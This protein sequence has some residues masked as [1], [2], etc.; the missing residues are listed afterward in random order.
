MRCFVALR[1]WEL[2]TPDPTRMCGDCKSPQTWGGGRLRD[3]FGMPSGLGIYWDTKAELF[4][5]EFRCLPYCAVAPEECLLLSPHYF[6]VEMCGG[7]VCTLSCVKY[8]FIIRFIV[9][10]PVEP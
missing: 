2:Q 5:R 1:Q 8:R 7:Y 9:A 6:M 10:L 4:L 3:S